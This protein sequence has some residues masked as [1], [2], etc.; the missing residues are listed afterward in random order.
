MREHLRGGG[1]AWHSGSGQWGGQCGLGAE[2][3]NW[4]VG[5]GCLVRGHLRGGQVLR[6]WGVDSGV[7]KVVLGPSERIGEWAQ[8]AWGEGV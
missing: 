3:A 8:A 4:R 5:S 7:D 6:V 2:R 1:S